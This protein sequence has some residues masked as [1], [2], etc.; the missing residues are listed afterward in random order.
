MKLTMHGVNSDYTETGENVSLRVIDKT[1][2]IIELE[3]CY[4]E[5][6]SERTKRIRLLGHDL[7]RGLHLLLV[8]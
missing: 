1:R 8:E 3:L 4:Q 5:G 6:G 2:S 7:L